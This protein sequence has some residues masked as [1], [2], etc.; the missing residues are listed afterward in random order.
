VQLDWDD[1]SDILFVVDGR[2]F[3]P[4]GRLFEVPAS[5]M[6]GTLSISAAFLVVLDILATT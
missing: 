6:R 2:L 4:E 3:V 1:M 5:P